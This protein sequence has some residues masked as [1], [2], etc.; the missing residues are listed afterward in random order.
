MDP[1]IE[2]ELAAHLVAV[3]AIERQSLRL[4]TSAEALADDRQ[5]ADAYRV[6][7][8]ARTLARRTDRGTRRQWAAYRSHL[9]I[10]LGDP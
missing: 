1:N 9:S 10:G 7:R 4:L 6:H 3:Q 2:T 8:S 5:I